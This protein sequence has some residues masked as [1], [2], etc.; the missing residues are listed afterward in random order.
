MEVLMGPITEIGAGTPFK[1]QDTYDKLEK[2]ENEKLKSID[3]RTDDLDKKKQS[4]KKLGDHLHLL[5][6]INEN[7]LQPKGMK[8]VTGNSMSYEATVT[9][10]V[11]TGS[12]NIQINQ[13][14]QA[15]E[16]A[17]QKI[18]ISDIEKKPL[19]DIKKPNLKIIVSTDSGSRQE[20]VMPHYK[21]TFSTLVEEINKQQSIINATYVKNEEGSYQLILTSKL[22]GESHGFS[23]ETDD[24]FLGPLLNYTPT[25]NIYEMKLI[26]KAQDSE[27]LIDGMN[28]KRPSNS[29]IDAPNGLQIQLKRIT[30]GEEN[31]TIS[32]DTNLK[33]KR[34]R[35]LIDELNNTLGFI[36]NESSA[37]IKNSKLIKSP[38]HGDDSVFEI[39][40]ELQKIQGELTHNRNFI[41]V[42]TLTKD[43]KLEVND[44]LLSKL[45]AGGNFNQE[46]D[47]DS[48]SLFVNLLSK[49]DS[50][51][52]KL[53]S[54]R[55]MLSN[56]FERLNKEINGNELER[57]R[58]VQ[59]IQKTLAFYRKQFTQL[60][61]FYNKLNTASLKLSGMLR[62]TNE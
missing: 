21:T 32:D 6:E 39:K 37:T 38:L 60:S 62:D 54:S 36:N 27:I 7:F 13:L 52:E 50:V 22:S 29:I 42:F 12:Y 24:K 11:P 61:L 57:S 17:S 46:K 41:G 55:G 59:E 25:N 23:I 56:G 16:L 31:F 26:K 28:I 44:Q 35:D 47:S 33:E 3:A 45:V 2:N 20:I 14:A 49:M 40:R 15:Q 1:L 53:T 19:S 9:G 30:Q 8:T 34:I 4:L 51:F 48:Y 5:K 43:G 10:H 18:Y 58:K